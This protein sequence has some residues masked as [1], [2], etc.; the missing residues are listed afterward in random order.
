MSDLQESSILLELRVFRKV[1]FVGIEGFQGFCSGQS[2]VLQWSI[3]GNTVGQAVA[4]QWYWDWPS[5]GTGTGPVVVQGWPSS[6]TGGGCQ[7]PGT[8]AHVPITPGTSPHM[9]VTV[10][11]GQYG[12]RHVSVSVRCSPGFFRIGDPQGLRLLGHPL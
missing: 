8:G 1:L 11:P 12:V 3:S 9:A 2:V 5:S 4:I 6:G 10:S 7:Y